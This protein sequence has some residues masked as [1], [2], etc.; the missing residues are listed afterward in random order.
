VYDEPPRGIKGKGKML[1]R[2]A[3]LGGDIPQIKGLDDIPM[4]EAHS[5]RFAP[6]AAGVRLSGPL[7]VCDIRRRPEGLWQVF[8]EV[9]PVNRT[10]LLEFLG[11]RGIDTSALT[12]A[13]P[14]QVLLDFVR[15]LEAKEHEP[16]DQE[17]QGMDQPMPGG[18]DPA[19]AEAQPDEPTGE[20]PTEMGEEFPDWP[21]PKDDA[22]KAAYREKC[23]KYMEHAKKMHSMYGEGDETDADDMETT[24]DLN[25]SMDGDQEMPMKMSEVQALVAREVKDALAKEAKGSLG[26]L[27]KFA[28]E[29]KAAE[30]KRAV[31]DVIDRLGREGK[32]APAERATVKARLLRADARTVVS[33]FAENGK[34][35]EATEFDLQV[36]ELERR[37]T[38]FGE[39]FKAPEGAHDEGTDKGTIE[40]FAELNERNF[41]LAGT[42]PKEFVA[43][44]EKSSPDEKARTLEEARRFLGGR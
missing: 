7:K 33:K 25:P 6:G 44:W 22:E 36:R 38:R 23:R 3:F 31:D 35:V 8:S 29:T 14:D 32:L 27:Q 11:Q 5:E 18:P 15:A 42:D 16:M 39:Q 34:T 2:V 43:T 40:K 37:P 28:E 9:S 12:D 20:Q 26:E 1:R 17:K 41:G 21:P 24:P 10:Q 19:V 4:P 13:V 30:R